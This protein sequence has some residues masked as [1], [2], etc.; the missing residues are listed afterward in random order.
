MNKKTQVQAIREVF[1][2]GI[3]VI[4][5]VSIFYFLYNFLIPQIQDYALGLQLKNVAEHANYLISEFYKSSSQSLSSFAEGKYLMPEKLGDY[6]YSVFFSGNE[7]CSLI[8]DLNIERCVFVLIDS[9]YQGFFYS[10]GE[11]KISINYTESSSSIMIG[12]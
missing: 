11:M 2:F 8:Q 10:G 6:S 12:N 9:S 4:F 7:I 5:L 3:G 1:Q